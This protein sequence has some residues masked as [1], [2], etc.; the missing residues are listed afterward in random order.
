MTFDSKREIDHLKEILTQRIDH[1]QT[2]LNLAAA[3]L[4]QRLDSMNLFREQLR[5]QAARFV[6]RSEVDLMAGRRDETTNRLEVKMSNLEGR[7][8]AFGAVVLL[9]ASAIGAFPHLIK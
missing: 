7:L 1:Q 2:A 9:A 4:E 3:A 5:D 6:T 8:W